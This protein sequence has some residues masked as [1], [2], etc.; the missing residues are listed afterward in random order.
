M[1]CYYHYYYNN[2]NNMITVT[3]IC[4]ICHVPYF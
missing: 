3:Y 1:Y 2:H 4:S